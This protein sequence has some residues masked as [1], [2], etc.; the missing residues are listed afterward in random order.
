ML[1][2]FQVI[3][4]PSPAELSG[5]QGY[6]QPGEEEQEQVEA[7]R[8]ESSINSRSA[9]AATAA[10]PH[11]ERRGKGRNWSQGEIWEGRNWSQ[12]GIWAAQAPTG[13]VLTSPA[14]TKASHP[15]SGD[16]AL[17]ARRKNGA[18]RKKNLKNL[19]ANLIFF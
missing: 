18:S 16:S 3:R 19:E 8:K 15:H 13:A 12:G 6:L 9:Q 14:H 5:C 4:S 10:Q 17:A 7:G 1:R 2:R 11:P